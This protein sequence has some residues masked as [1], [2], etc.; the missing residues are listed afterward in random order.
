MRLHSLHV[1]WTGKSFFF[2]LFSFLFFSYFLLFNSKKLFRTDLCFFVCI[3]TTRSLR[4][5]KMEKEKIS[6]QFQK[7]KHCGHSVSISLWHIAIQQ[8]DQSL[9]FKEGKFNKLPW[10]QS[11]LGRLAVFATAL[12][13]CRITATLLCKGFAIEML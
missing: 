11:S 2:S 4:I 7:N 10:F 6:L 3:L 9:T 5:L 1:W 12:W 13:T 8:L